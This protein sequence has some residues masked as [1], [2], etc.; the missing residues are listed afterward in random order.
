MRPN[1]IEVS[2]GAKKSFMDFTFFA[3]SSKEWRAD[4]KLQFDE[5]VGKLS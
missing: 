3:V 1:Y 5:A 4:E 2:C